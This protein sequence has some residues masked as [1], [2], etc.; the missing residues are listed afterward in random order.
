[1][2]PWEH[3]AIA[4]ISCS[5]VIRMSDAGPVDRSEFFA[6]LLG[7][8][9][10]DLIDKPASWLF[11]VFPSGVSVAHSV[12]IAV[13]IA[14]FVLILTSR[15]E[16]TTA[17]LAFIAGYLLHL[18]ADALYPTILRGTAPQVAVFL[19]PIVPAA[20]N[21]P[22]GFLTNV[23]FY[24]LQYPEQLMTVGAWVVLLELGLVG[25]A[26]ALWLLDGTPGIAKRRYNPTSRG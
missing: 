13:P 12:F 2:Y 9:F 1:M 8:Q 15:R 11:E 22:G 14:V 20:P 21:P 7:S 26:F 25:S 17:G 10:P 5:V 19:W 3:F 6:I 24:L 18:P 16:N 4:Y 23:Q